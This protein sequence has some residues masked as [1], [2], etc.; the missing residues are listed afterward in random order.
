MLG[1]LAS[2]YISFYDFLIETNNYSTALFFFPLYFLAVFAMY[3]IAYRYLVCVANDRNDRIIIKIFSFMPLL[4]TLITWAFYLPLDYESKYKFIQQNLNQ[5]GNSSS[6]FFFFQIIIYSLYYIQIIIFIIIFIQ[7]Y[8]LN[9]KRE[10]S[11]SRARNLFLPKWLFFV[12]AIF[13]LYE[14]IYFVLF[15]IEVNLQ[16]DLITQL[17]N[18]LFIIFIG[19]LGIK[20]DE[21]VISI[22]LDN[23]FKNKISEPKEKIKKAFNEEEA[24]KIL[25]EIKSLLEEE[26]LYLNPA[27]K[28][29]LVA[30]K[31]HIPINSLSEIINKLE[32]K[33]FSQFINYY[34]IEEAKKLMLTTKSESIEDIFLQVGFYT[35]STFNRAF[36]SITHKTP[37]EFLKSINQ[38]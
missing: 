11:L 3:P 32:G 14:T 23:L 27:L 19:I 26:K 13:I 5:L 15:F 16:F 30:K 1:M 18:L 22:Q 20:H 4:A 12:I 9:K 36:K 24:K 10:K 21:F 37:T 28:I 31:L 35:R 2:V 38:D 17:I 29:E 7:I 6:L 34:R 33:N 25:A 8:L